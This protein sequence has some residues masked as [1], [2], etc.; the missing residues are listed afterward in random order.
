MMQLTTLADNVIE[1]EQNKRTGSLLCV[2]EKGKVGRIYY[3]D[4][5]AVTAA[6]REKQGED[7]Q[8]ALSGQRFRTSRFYDG[9]NLL[10]TNK[11]RQHNKSKRMPS[12]ASLGEV[13]AM[14]RQRSRVVGGGLLTP[15]LRHKLAKEL[16]EHLG[17]AAA[18][19]VEALV[20]TTTL[21]DAVMALSKEIND[22]RAVKRFISAFN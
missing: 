7:A 9:K 2:D 4:G 16:S 5:H 13:G 3:V 1:I 11:K 12:A 19:L 21:T 10:R 20:D 6:Y 17:P 14:E 8:V 22:K 15:V 18:V